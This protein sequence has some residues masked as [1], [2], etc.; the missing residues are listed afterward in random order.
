M[1][2]N[3]SGGEENRNACDKLRAFHYTYLVYHTKER[4]LSGK[5]ESITST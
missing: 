3:Y 2:S 4:Q 1:N 5:I